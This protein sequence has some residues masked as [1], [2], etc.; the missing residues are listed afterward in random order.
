MGSDKYVY[1]H[2]SCWGL[3]PTGYMTH[4]HSSQSDRQDP[5]GFWS[6]LI[7]LPLQLLLLVLCHG[8]MVHTVEHVDSC[9]GWQAELLIHFNSGMSCEDIF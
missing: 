9:Y 6:A 2:G 8:L 5:S 4:Y 7:V 3:N 1:V